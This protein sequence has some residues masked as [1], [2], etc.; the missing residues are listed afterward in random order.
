MTIFDRLSS[1]EVKDLYAYL[2]GSEFIILNNEE[3]RKS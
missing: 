1:K 3:N 2:E